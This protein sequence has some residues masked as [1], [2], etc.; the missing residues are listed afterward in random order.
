MYT[1]FFSLGNRGSSRFFSFQLLK[2]G[3]N[4]CLVARIHL[5]K[6]DT[7]KS[8]QM[9]NGNGF[10]IFPINAFEIIKKQDILSQHIVMH[11]NT[12]FINPYIRREKTD[13]GK[14]KENHGK[15]S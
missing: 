5:M 11:H 13:E 2:K 15:Q 7:G 8:L 14:E 10:V 6:L 9:E 12:I 1:I 4:L 3:N